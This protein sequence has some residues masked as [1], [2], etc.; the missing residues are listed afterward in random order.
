MVWERVG[1][2]SVAEW[3]ND[4][5]A[6]GAYEHKG[7]KLKEA[8]RTYTHYEFEPECESMSICVK[9]KQGGKR[10]P[11]AHTRSTR[12]DVQKTASRAYAQGTVKST[13]ILLYLELSALNSHQRTVPRC[14]VIAAYPQK[15]DLY[16]RKSIRSHSMLQTIFYHAPLPSYQIQRGN[17][18]N[19]FMRIRARYTIKYLVYSVP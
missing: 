6:I 19:R 11:H 10:P 2:E 4:H 9:P 5:R 12:K 14:L 8:S 1:R 15:H 13:L 16:H 7:L 18:K 3:P 17:P